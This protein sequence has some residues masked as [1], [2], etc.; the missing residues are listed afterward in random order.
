MYKGHTD[1]LQTKTMQRLQSKFFASIRLAAW[2]LESAA[3]RPICSIR[4][5]SVSSAASSPPPSSSALI[6]ESEKILISRAPSAVPNSIP[7]PQRLHGT[8][9]WVFLGAPGVG[10]GTYASRAA[11]HFN[12]AHIATGDLIRAEIKEGTSVGKQV[13]LLH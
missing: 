13:E 4:E 2:H 6:V 12:A 11:K 5:L 1:T 7:P 9:K 10:K 8:I 3:D